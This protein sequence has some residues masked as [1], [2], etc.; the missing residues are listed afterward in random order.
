[1][2]V[3]RW[4]LG[5]GLLVA[6]CILLL[7]P[8]SSDAEQLAFHVLT[9]FPENSKPQKALIRGARRLS[10]ESDGQVLM[11]Y[12]TA[13]EPTGEFMLS[14][15]SADDSLSAALVPSVALQD[16]MPNADLYG[17]LFLFRDNAEVAHVRERMDKVLLATLNNDDFITVGL[18][19]IGFL[20]FMGD[21]SVENI[22][23]L[24]GRTVWMPIESDHD[25]AALSE[26]SLK[27]VAGEM[28]SIVSDDA[29]VSLL[30][31]HN[32]TALIL[33][34]KIPRPQYL[35][36]PPLRYGYFLLIVKRSVW[37][38]LEETDLAIINKTLTEQLADI[39][40]KARSA[41]E[42]SLRL[43][44]RRGMSSVELRDADALRPVGEDTL[45]KPGLQQR[46]VQALDNYRSHS[47][48]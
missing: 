8:S 21:D 45:F 32:P 12:V 31:I 18:A 5:A 24:A 19:G 1:M 2:F 34:K 11:R 4:Q 6:V 41:A 33:N 16:Q 42:R 9:V 23:A 28:P 15:F 43:L 37:E 30:M 10:R 22:E 46:L 13:N 25:R 36:Q 3:D 39:E 47:E 35:M 40:K 14:Q 17:Q 44:K 27:T 48:K 29:G 7:A 26:L 20:Y 38:N